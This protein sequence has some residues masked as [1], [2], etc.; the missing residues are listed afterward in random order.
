VDPLSRRELWAIIEQLTGEQNLTVLLS[1]AYLDDAQRCDDTIV[2]HEGQLLAQ[3]VPREISGLANGRT[4]LVRPESGQTARGLQAKLLSE[5]TVVDAVPE[6]GQ[7]RLVLE[8]DVDPQ[9]AVRHLP[10]DS[11]A[12]PTAAK[13]EDGFM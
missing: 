9:Q 7:V 11:P 1:T 6:G 8:R 2:L 4:F 10:I 13:F 3:G 5:P 12:T